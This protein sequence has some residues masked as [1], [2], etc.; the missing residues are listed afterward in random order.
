MAEKK[1]DALRI[2]QTMHEEHV[3]EYKSKK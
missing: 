3:V 1:E 2:I